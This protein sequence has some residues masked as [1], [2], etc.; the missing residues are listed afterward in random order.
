MICAKLL[1]TNNL[2]EKFYFRR[3]GEPWPGKPGLFLCGRTTAVKARAKCFPSAEEAGET[4]LKINN[5]PGW[6][7]VV[8]DDDE[9]KE[10]CL[11]PNP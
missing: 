8:E 10:P 11:A 3:L 2:G 6:S 7:I 9:S 1:Y 5:P 4:L